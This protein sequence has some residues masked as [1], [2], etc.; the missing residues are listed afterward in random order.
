MILK[1]CK[2]LSKQ[3]NNQSDNPDSKSNNPTRKMAGPKSVTLFVTIRCNHCNHFCNLFKP[4]LINPIQP[5]SSNRVRL[6]TKL[7]VE[8]IFGAIFLSGILKF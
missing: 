5:K 2:Q 4:Q 8:K 3:E 1:S 6:E 7:I